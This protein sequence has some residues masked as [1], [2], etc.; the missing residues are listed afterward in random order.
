[1]VNIILPSRLTT[2]QPPCP[3]QQTVHAAQP[4]LP[5]NSIALNLLIPLPY[6]LLRKSHF[7]G[8]QLFL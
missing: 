6:H 1:M 8:S 7:S 5:L 2:E 4:S 3:H